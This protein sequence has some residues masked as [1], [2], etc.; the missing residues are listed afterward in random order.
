LGIYENQ[1]I[2]KLAC[3]VLIRKLLEMVQLIDSDLV[4]INISETTMDFCYDIV[5]E[6]EDYTMGKILEYILYET[7]YVTEK[8]LSFC[9][10]KKYHP[11]N[12]DS[13]IRVAYK[14]PTDR[15]MVRQH[16]KTACIDAEKVY[17][18]LK[19]LF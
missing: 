1:E 5:L 16:L 4:P 18:Q 11:H 3:D 10:F 17:K 9:G 6:N 14:E 7:F 8:K 19:G 2:V 13:I 12:T 15:N